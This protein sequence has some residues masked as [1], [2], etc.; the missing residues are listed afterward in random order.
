MTQSIDGEVLVSGNSGGGFLAMLD[1]LWRAS[2]AAYWILL[3]VFF[4]IFAVAKL[5]EAVKRRGTAKKKEEKTYWMIQA[6]Q[7][8][9]WLYIVI[10]FYY[11]LFQDFLGVFVSLET[12]AKITWMFEAATGLPGLVWYFLTDRGVFLN[13]NATDFAVATMIGVVGILL[14]LLAI[15]YLKV[16]GHL[17]IADEWVSPARVT[18]REHELFEREEA[19]YRALS[20]Q[21]HEHEMRHPRFHPAWDELSREQQEKLIDKWD[22][23]KAAI[24]KKI[25]ECP[26]ASYFN[27][28]K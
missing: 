12:R 16:F 3:F 10:C 11:H 6:A 27:E 23:E 22:N 7:Y 19:P 28:S 8:W 15:D 26:R 2:V 21:R 24:R 20:K 4:P 25:D 5:V 1:R 13:G 14:M 9:C 17:N 18:R